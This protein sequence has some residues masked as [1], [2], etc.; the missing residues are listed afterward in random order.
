MDMFRLS[1]LFLPGQEVESVGVERSGVA[2]NNRTSKQDTVCFNQVSLTDRLYVWSLAAFLIIRT[3]RT[4]GV[5]SSWNTLI[6]FIQEAVFVHFCNRGRL[7]NKLIL[8]NFFTF[9][10]QILLFY[11]VTSVCCMKSTHNHHI[12]TSIFVFRPN[13]PSQKLFK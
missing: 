10:K 4:T 3:W 1:T 6:C 7:T 5:P 11:E 13:Y 12:R 8:T 2:V 9:T